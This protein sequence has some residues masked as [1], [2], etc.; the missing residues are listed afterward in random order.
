MAYAS[1]HGEKY[2]KYETECSTL[3]VWQPALPAWPPA[4]RSTRRAKTSSPEGDRG[5][6]RKRC[7]AYATR[8]ACA[9]C[10]PGSKNVVELVV[11]VTPWRR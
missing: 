9:A 8:G 3:G 1:T 2:E 11:G 6:V 7:K 4:L 5:E 10:L